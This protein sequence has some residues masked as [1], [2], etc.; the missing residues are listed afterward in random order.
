MS[1]KRKQKQ[2][3]IR[4]FSLKCKK[5]GP[6]NHDPK[7]YKTYLSTDGPVFRCVHVHKIQH[8]ARHHFERRET[9]QVPSVTLQVPTPPEA[10]C[11]GVN[12][13]ILIS[14]Y[15]TSIATAVEINHNSLRVCSR[16]ANPSI[17][18]NSPGCILLSTTKSRKIPRI[19]CLSSTVSDARSIKPERQGHRSSRSA[20]SYAP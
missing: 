18:T 10:Q 4:G 8:S 12:K 2:T 6:V 1:A 17:V 7:P 15:E 9:I 19:H 13:N 14:D 3:V 5:K 11:Y 16:I 20:R